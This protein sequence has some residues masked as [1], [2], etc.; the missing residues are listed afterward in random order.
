MTHHDLIDLHADAALLKIADMA[1]E[2]QAEIVARF[3]RLAAGT[4][5]YPHYRAAIARANRS[6]G[7]KR[8]WR[9]E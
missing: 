8:R 9:K 1:R 5:A 6:A 2:R 7:Q 4:P 3:D